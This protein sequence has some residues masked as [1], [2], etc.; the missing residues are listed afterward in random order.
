MVL[1]SSSE[2]EE[3]EEKNDYRDIIFEEQENDKVIKKMMM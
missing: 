3:K 2:A 1:P